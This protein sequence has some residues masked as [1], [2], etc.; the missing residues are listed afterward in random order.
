MFLTRLGHDSRAVVT[1]DVTQVDLPSGARSGL[2]DALSVLSGVEGIHFARLTEQDVVRHSLVQRIVRA[3]ERVTVER[4]SSDQ[5][6][7][8]PGPN[9]GPD[10]Q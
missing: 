5:A 2:M 4:A 9:P 3:Y 10:T 8:S 7:A 6:D 1:G